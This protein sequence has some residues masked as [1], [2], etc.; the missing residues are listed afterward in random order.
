MFSSAKQSVPCAYRGLNF[1]IS[2]NHP[3]INQAWAFFV[4][5]WG[6][7]SAHTCNRFL[8]SN[9]FPPN[10]CPPC[11]SCISKS[12]CKCCV[13]WTLKETRGFLF[14]F[15]SPFHHNTLSPCRWT[16]KL[17]WYVSFKMES[18]QVKVFVADAQGC[19]KHTFSSPLRWTGKL[20]RN[21]WHT[22]CMNLMC[23]VQIWCKQRSN[24]KKKEKTPEYKSKEPQLLHMF[25]EQIISLMGGKLFSSGLC[26]SLNPLF[27]VLRG[28]VCLCCF[29]ALLSGLDSP[30]PPVWDKDIVFVS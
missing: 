20:H 26:E 6:I 29:C 24:W 15:F 3:P 10:I 11:L 22:K 18:T 2:A 16:W 13:I 7:L 28:F 1:P 23:C 19:I 4:S 5:P 21:E 9:Q 17:A 14:F 30:Y 27:C 8:S 25:T 12:L